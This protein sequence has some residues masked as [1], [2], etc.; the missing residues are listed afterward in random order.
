[1]PRTGLWLRIFVALLL[2]VLPPILL[3]VG[4]LLL[5]ESVLA[6]VDP[7]VVA[8]MVVVGAVVWAAILGVV[9]ARTIADDIRSFVSLAQ[10][11]EE[12]ADP[13]LG[14]AYRQLA[15]TLDERNRQVATL[16]REASAVP[17]DEQPRQV[18][19]SLVSAVRSVMRDATWRCAVLASDDPELL[20]PGGLPRR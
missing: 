14:A 8:V 12:V 11:G 4:A 17:I 9:F 19:A 15:T 16:A 2:A 6:D 1:M 5:T 13:E 3:L 10:R 20:P 18:V 7:N